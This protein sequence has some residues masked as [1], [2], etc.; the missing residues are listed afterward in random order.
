M[1]NKKIVRG[2]WDPMFF[3]AILCMLAI[4]I[5]MVYSASYFAMGYQK[6]DPNSLIIKELL[7]VTAGLG[8][9]WVVSRIPHN[10]VRRLTFPIVIIT[11]ISYGLLYTPLGVRLYGGLRWV[12][13]GTRTL[14]FMPSELAKYAGILAISY[15]RT[16]SKE[17][18]AQKRWIYIFLCF[19]PLLFLALTAIQP[20]YS[21]TVLMAMCY[22]T[23]LFFSGLKVS[24]LVVL[25]GVGSVLGAFVL[26]LKGYRV[27]RIQAWFDPFSDPLKGGYQIIQ[28]LYAVAS[29]GLMGSGIGSG[30]QKMLYL[31]LA[32]NDYIFSVYAEEMGFFGCMILLVIL[33][34]LVFRGFKIASNAPDRFSTLMAGGIVA[35]I[36]L[37]SIMHMY[38]AVNLL[39]STGIPFPIISYGGTS[40]VVTLMGMGFVLG[41][42]RLE[43][44][45]TPKA[46][47]NVENKNYYSLERRD[48]A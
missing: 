3:I 44:R 30:K 1:K 35:Q 33:S 40:L 32:Y 34:A 16:M 26:M 37:Q 21:T 20:D 8:A 17:E 10:A 29:G 4:G 45:K 24:V 18:K 25:A 39:P 36:A 41:V 27:A 13:L 12:K 43:N 47:D 46:F 22:I 14:T 11:F 15:V 28:S 2:K 7:F 38:V 42:S 19:T 48:R 23:V 9:A 5:I 6:D 31:P